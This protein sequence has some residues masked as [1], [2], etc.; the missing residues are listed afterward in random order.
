MNAHAQ[1][2]AALRNL[3]DVVEEYETKV[4]AVDE[5]EKAFKDAVNAVDLASVIGGTYV[6]SIW[7]RARPSIRARTI[8]ENLLKSAWRHVYD[9][10]NIKHVAS[11]ADRS[12]FDMDL[13]NPAEFTLE[14]IAAT[15]GDYLQN[16]RFHILKGLAECF[17]GLDPAYRSHSKVK[18]GVNGLPKRIIINSVVGDYGIRG[19]GADRLSDTINAL[20]IFQG[21]PHIEYGEFS[22]L[23]DTARKAGSAEYKGLTLKLFKNGNGHL[24]FSKHKLAQINEALAEFYGDTLPDSPEAAPKKRP[25]TDIAKDLQFYPTPRKV[26]DEVI[27][28]ELYDL[29]GK[30]MLEPSCGEGAMMEALREAFPSAHLLGIEVH[31]ERAETARAKGFNVV[32]KNFLA[33][34]PHPAFDLVLMNP[35]FYGTHWRKH[36]DHAIKFLRPAPEDRRWDRGQVISILPATAWYD[37]H[38]DDLCGEWRDLPVASFAASGTNVPTGY[39][40][41]SGEKK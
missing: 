13:E 28:R 30:K 14:N 20:N 22:D 18:V 21:D 35:P 4:A 26:I 8:K 6:G 1:V 3:R 17:V 37:G 31:G 12:R 23:L 32:C 40:K 41:T 24:I 34:A 2:P 15:F 9:G 19:H 29:N 7:Y 11:A 27:R 38:L 25:G 5:V 39:F 36:L 10:L 33:T 16:P